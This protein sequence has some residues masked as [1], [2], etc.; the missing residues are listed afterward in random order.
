MDQRQLSTNNGSLDVDSTNGDVYARNL[1]G[2][3]QANAYWTVAL[4]LA[5]GTNKPTPAQVDVING[6]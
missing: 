5:Y 1:I 2:S 6:R 3:A 4:F